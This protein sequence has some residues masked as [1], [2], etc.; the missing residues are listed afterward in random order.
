MLIEPE[1]TLPPLG[2]VEL[3]LSAEADADHAATKA[4]AAA[5]VRS[6]V[7]ARPRGG[8]GA[9]G[10]AEMTPT[11]ARSVI[12]PDNGE[13][14]SGLRTILTHDCELHT[15]TPYRKEPKNARP[16]VNPPI[17]SV[18]S[19]SWDLGVLLGICSPSAPMRQFRAS[20]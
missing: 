12:I 4:A 10:E 8:R 13:P 2:R 15:P 1:A 5:V 19:A 14:A 18:S 20:A 6:L 11:I 3:M 17:L 7:K 9:G 16:R